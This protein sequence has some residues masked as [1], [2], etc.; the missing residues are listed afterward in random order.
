MIQP[1]GPSAEILRAWQHG[2][3]ELIVCPELLGE[4]ED[5]L[6]RP[7]LRDRVSQDQ[8]V[9]FI[10]LLR[11]QAELRADPAR[12]AGLT[13]D[14]K[15]DYVVAR[16]PARGPTPAPRP[17]PR[18]GEGRRGAGPAAPWT[19]ASD[20]DRARCH[21]AGCPPNSGS[22]PGCRVTAPRENRARR[23]GR[24]RSTRRRRSGRR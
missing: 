15:D 4:L 16:G 23:P 18:V 11:S 7:K 5:V 10:R 8:A 1:L 12:A 3:L 6:D 22:T 13:A 24:C 2:D 14:E 19:T 20:P 17:H 9:A 21:R